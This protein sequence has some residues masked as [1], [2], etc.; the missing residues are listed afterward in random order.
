VAE[1]THIQ[2]ADAGGGRPLRKDAER[3]RR[4]ILQAAGEVFAERGLGVT[5]DEIARH[6]GVGVG[7]VYRRFP[8]K[9][10]LIEALFAERLDR[11]SAAAERGLATADAWD[12]LVGFLHDALELQAADRGLKELMCS[13]S[14]GRDRIAEARERLKPLIDG[15]V[16]RA[17][18]DGAL[19]EDVR[20]QD[21]ALLHVMLGAVADVTRDVRADHWR[22]FLALLVDG[23]RARGGPR[24]P[25]P[26]TA[27]G[28]DELERA[29]QAPA[30]RG[31]AGRV[32]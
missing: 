26:G 32:P 17:H 24:E 12:G 18:A 6:A 13:T 27:L 11:L 23:L 29:M 4:R 7:T 21:L 25:L 16:A 20:G 31:P 8:G 5:L 15:L 28:D 2:A 14:H 3:N 1:Q 22:R 9:E 10:D 19:R 30:G